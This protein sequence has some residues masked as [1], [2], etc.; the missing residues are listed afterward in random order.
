MYLVGTVSNPPVVV[1]VNNRIG[2]VPEKS[3][4]LLSAAEPFNMDTLY[5]KQ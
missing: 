3:Y 1:A 2:N 5:I 4:F